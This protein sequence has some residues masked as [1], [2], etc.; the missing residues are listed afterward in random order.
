M[1]RISRR[2][3]AGAGLVAALA[4]GSI[5]VDGGGVRAGDDPP[6]PN[7]VAPS[8]P[9]KPEAP[10]A[11][12]GGT[13]RLHVVGPDGTPVP[14]ALVVTTIRGD[15]SAKTSSRD[16][17]SGE[18]TIGASS[19]DCRVEVFAATDADGN[20]L[21]LGIYDR[22]LRGASGRVEVVLP[23]G[24][25]IS[26]RVRLA[27]GSGLKD[28]EVSARTESGREFGPRGVHRAARTAEDGSFSLVGVGDREYSL[29]VVPG[30]AHPAP[31]PVTVRGGDSNVD[32]VLSAG[33]GVVSVS[34]VDSQD[35][36]ITGTRVNVYSAKARDRSLTG[37]V[38]ERLSD[39]NG[40]FELKGLDPD[41]T[42][43]LRF[44]LPQDRPDLASVR[45]PSWQPQSEI[46]RVPRGYEVSGTVR[47]TTRRPVANATVR[48]VERGGGTPP[49]LTGKDGKFRLI[50]LTYGPALL[51]IES[52][53]ESRT[54]MRARVAVT[55]EKPS[56]DIVVR[57]ISAEAEVT[58]RV[59]HA[60]AGR[61]A[62]LF[63]RD[64]D[65]APT[66]L[67]VSKDGMIRLGS[68]DDAY[69]GTLWIPAAPPE[70][71]LTLCV[72]LV[73]FTP[74]E[75]PLTPLPSGKF[76][77]KVVGARA[78]DAATVRASRYG[79]PRFTGRV[80]TAGTFEVEGVAPGSW[81]VVALNRKGRPI[82]SAVLVAKSGETVEVELSV[83]GK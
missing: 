70:S 40:A 53:E 83:P 15:N 21:P 61:R 45:R 80:V 68:G 59:R 74:R 5:G 34:L 8:D 65:E 7:P 26:G 16:V 56:I 67:R 46:I 57:P 73:G 20:A 25:V 58:R 12:K 1:D 24:T 28:A 29:E 55:P 81:S 82:A 13:V 30:G 51:S 75:T 3:S 2:R 14:R 79:G 41:E 44:T 38:M 11:T 4:L 77:V 47:D 42:Y 19:G 23:V 43:D 27:D 33:P 72:D 39:R 76:R 9:P 17:R 66:E 32:I 37:E 64:P 31:K 18:A 69:E 6:V 48:G 63:H 49:A 52:D 22:V 78:A 62:V 10:A 71:D 35:R 50:G 36:P 54:P 60:K